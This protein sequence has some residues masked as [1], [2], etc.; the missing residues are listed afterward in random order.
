MTLENLLTNRL[1]CTVLMLI[2]AVTGA[3]TVASGF[4]VTYQIVTFLGAR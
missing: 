4:W 2:G 3:V 1:F